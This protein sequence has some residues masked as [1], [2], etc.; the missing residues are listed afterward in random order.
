VGF[1]APESTDEFH[2][3]VRS[4]AEQSLVIAP[5]GVDRDPSSEQAVYPARFD[6]VIGVGGTV[7]EGPLVILTTPYTG[8]DVLAT[9]PLPGPLPNGRSEERGGA[10]IACAVFAGI[11]LRSLATDDRLDMVGEET[12]KQALLNLFESTADSDGIFRPDWPL[13]TE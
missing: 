8:C 7:A 12:R 13:S 11:V 10:S 2:T 9:T 5:T 6:E 3:T 1:G 4:L